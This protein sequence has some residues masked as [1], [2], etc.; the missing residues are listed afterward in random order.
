MVT[1][2]ILL[3]ITEFPG[4]KLMKKQGQFL[5]EKDNIILDRAHS[6]ENANYVVAH[7]NIH[8]ED[9]FSTYFSSWYDS[10]VLDTGATCH[11]TF[12][13]DFFDQFSDNIDG[14]VYFVD[15][16]QIK[17]SGIC[18]IHL[19]IPRLP[20]YVLNDVLYIPKFQ[21]NLLSLIQIR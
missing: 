10:W 5:Q 16:S 9:V 7:C 12:R 17:P 20:N 14:V 18:S 19:K 8:M 15:K 1:F 21:R 11:T 13:R 4:I 6:S 2:D 3:Q